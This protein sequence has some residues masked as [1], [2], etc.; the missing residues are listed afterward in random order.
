MSYQV[1]MGLRIDTWKKKLLDLGKR[2]RLLNYRDTKRGS[3]RIVEPSADDLWNSFVVDERSL[4]FPYVDEDALEDLGPEEVERISRHNGDIRTNKTLVEQQRTLRSLR[5]RART[6]ISEQGVNVLYLA[7]GFLRWTETAY[8]QQVLESPIVLVPASLQCESITS[9]YV[10]S[11]HDDEIVVNP[12]LSYKLENDFGLTIPPL[13]EDEP[14]GRYLER[15]REMVNAHGWSVQNDVCLSLLSFSKINMYMDLERHG[16]AIASHPIVRALAGDPSGMTFNDGLLPDSFDHDADAGSAADCHLVVDAD[17]SQMDAV[18]CAKRGVS[19]VLQGPPGTGKSQT[20]TNI[21]AESLADGKKV[22]FV[23]EKM[24]ALDVVHRRLESVGLGDFCLVLHSHKAN[25]KD[26][27][28]QLKKSLD[29][30]SKRV[31]LR[32]E[33]IQS[34]DRLRYDRDLLN[35]YARDLHTPI[36]PLG[37]TIFEAN[38]ELSSCSEAREMSFSISNVRSVSSDGF[39]GM[40]GY[41]RRFERVLREMGGTPK[42]NPWRGAQLSTVSNA[43]RHDI[44]AR[45]GVASELLSKLID[46]SGRTAELLGAECCSIYDL[47][48]SVPLLEVCG[49]S[50]LVPPHWVEGETLEKVEEAAAEARDRKAALLSFVSE[51]NETLRGMVPEG[52]LAE[53]DP[54]RDTEGWRLVLGELESQIKRLQGLE[55]CFSVWNE[56][57]P[58]KLDALVFDLEARLERVGGLRSSIDKNYDEGIYSIDPNPLLNRFDT[59]Y[60]Q[61]FLD[62]ISMYGEDRDAVQGVFRP[63]SIGM[64]LSDVAIWLDKAH[65]LKDLRNWANSSGELAE[66]NRLQE[67]ITRNCEAEIE[68]IPYDEIYLRFKEESSSILSFLN[69]QYREDKKL[70]STLIKGSGGKA[71]D[72]KILD[73]LSKLRRRDELMRW[74]SSSSE[75]SDLMS[76]ER[77]V[78][79][80]FTSD[81]FSLDCSGLSKRYSSRYTETFLCNLAQYDSDVSTI[82]SYLRDGDCR[83]HADIA[84]DLALLRDLN[85]GLS[86]IG[87]CS[88]EYERVLGEHFAGTGT[89]IV[90]LREAIS[91]YRSLRKAAEILCSLMRIVKEDLDVAPSLAWDFRGDFAGLGTDWGTI[92]EKISW[93]KRLMET[94]KNLRCAPSTKALELTCT[95][96]GFANRCAGLA[97]EVS[98]ELSRVSSDLGWF[99]SLFP[100]SENLEDTQVTSLLDRFSECANNLRALE[101]WVDYSNL[102]A[103]CDDYGLGDCV[104]EIERDALDPRE[105][106]PAFR[107]RFYTLWLDSVLPEY[108]SVG[109]FRRRRQDSTIDEFRELDKSQFDIARS[110]TKAKLINSLPAIDYLGHADIEVMTLLRELNKKRK[111]KPI[112]RLFGEIPNLVMTL[113]PC[114]MM[115]PLSVSLFLEASSFEFDIVIF[116]EASQVCTENAVGAIFRGKQVV[117]AGDS[118]QLPPTSFFEASLSESD[119]DGDDSDS[120]EIDDANAFESVLDEAAFLPSQKLLWHYRS[121]DERLIAFSNAKIYG[122]E[123]VTFP[124]PN[125]GIKDCGVE[126]EYVPNGVFDRGGSRAN[127]MEAERVA[128]LVFDH[129]T[130]N[131]HRSLGVIAFS[132]S[133]EAAIDTAIRKRR[134]SN[135][136]FEAFFDEERD[137]SFFVKNLENVQGDERDTII[138]SIGYA[139]DAAG[140]MRMNFGPLSRAGGERRLNVAITRAKYNVKLVGSILPTDIQIERVSADGPKLLR[141]YIEYAMRGQEVLEAELSVPDLVVT[142]SPFEDSVYDFLTSEG[143]RVATQVGCL[144][145]RIDMAVRHPALDGRFVLGIECDGATYHS[146]RT[147]RDRDRLRQEVL[148][149]MGWRIYRIW[150]TDWIKDPITEKRRLVEAVKIAIDEYVEDFPVQSTSAKPEQ[151]KLF[152]EIEEL[153]ERELVAINDGDLYHFAE[154]KE[155][156]YEQLPTDSYGQIQLRDAIELLVSCKYPIHRDAIAQELCPYLGYQRAGSKIKRIVNA[157]IDRM[158]SVELHGDFVYPKGY[159]AVPAYGG[160]GRTIKYISVDELCSALM[161]VARGLIGSTRESLIENTARAYGFNRIGVHISSALNEAFDRLVQEGKVTLLDNRV[162]VT[163]QDSRPLGGV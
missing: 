137:E 98:R 63:S 40:I 30:S 18:E 32:D 66:L 157:T 55:P 71:E 6:Y 24:A 84:C 49:S 103:D 67:E 72:E 8:S 127:S 7:F 29:Y 96:S 56:I 14:V 97:R 145:Y 65:R 35:A 13:S 154:M 124:S 101:N 116:D 79:D 158:K 106:L 25:K 44:T 143:Y 45:R 111:I 108:P 152:D 62:S 146:A 68:H 122:H 46:L 138:F 128:D 77:E 54:L 110:A 88:P 104:G 135:S 20:I 17:S 109:N 141:S 151:E 102:R 140:V 117:I 163:Q 1:N 64:P 126:Y 139:K 87:E 28:A 133:Q 5:N 59:V 125:E 147:A 85:D 105:I 43:L 113:R 144:G 107:K 2:N 153:E 38:G 4:E 70:V 100:A 75:F 41:L 132:S 129:F 21:I 47:K 86:S 155:P 90:S 3:I 80:R 93:T 76:L 78:N 114:L 15:L 112:R 120:E 94:L 31:T 26:V 148:E 23:S 156:E 160:Q 74:R 52:D 162:K 50:P 118:K 83:G 36:S 58:D 81:V 60:D 91:K 123:L 150:S 37:R 10:L 82:V 73:V 42:D 19:F 121:R 39:A 142:E 99:L 119:Y 51:L 136:S 11:P 130:R 34:L 131:P 22:L 12:T 95:D 161:L 53:I 9:P 33:A 134:K 48:Q 92:S 159:E 27:L 115:S 16:D 89:D 149:G 69:K 57:D 61:P